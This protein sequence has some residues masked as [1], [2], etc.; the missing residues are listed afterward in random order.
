MC[1]YE[2]KRFLYNNYKNVI[3]FAAKCIIYLLIVYLFFSYT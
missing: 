2:R 1:H 3:A